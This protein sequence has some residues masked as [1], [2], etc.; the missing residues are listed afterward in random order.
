MKPLVLSCLPGQVPLAG[1]DREWN[2]QIQESERH[3]APA[4]NYAVLVPSLPT[5]SLPYLPWMPLVHIWGIQVEY[6]EV[7]TH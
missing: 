6:T 5:P 1:T 4:H 2:Q 3:T 7:S